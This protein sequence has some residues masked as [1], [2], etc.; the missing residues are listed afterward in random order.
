MHKL[1]SINELIHDSD[2]NVRL[3]TVGSL[4]SLLSQDIYD[5]NTVN[6]LIQIALNGQED[7]NVRVLAATYITDD[8][9][10]KAVEVLLKLTK[11]PE[12]IIREN[13]ADLLGNFN[14]PT[15]IETLISLLRDTNTFVRSSASLSLT[16]LTGQ[17]FGEDY[18][19]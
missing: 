4:G 16:K 19:K 12:F 15:V 7:P 11:D 9:K 3:Y 5:E 13:A 18:Q 14:E 8:I 10:D 1:S 17:D 2:S 6:T